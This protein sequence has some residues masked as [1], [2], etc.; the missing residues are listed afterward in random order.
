[1]WQELYVSP[2]SFVTVHW[3]FPASPASHLE[4]IS[5][6]VSFSKWMLCLSSFWMGSPLWE[7]NISKGEEPETLPSKT[8]SLPFTMLADSRGLTKAGGST[9]ETRYCHFH[10]HTH[11]LVRLDIKT[12]DMKR[13]NQPLTVTVQLQWSLPATLDAT[14]TYSPLSSMLLSITSREATKLEKHNSCL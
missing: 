4:T 11:T 12:W 5:V 9:L 1:M 10:T 14:Q 2:T 6:M 7:Q 13:L 8:M 3:Y